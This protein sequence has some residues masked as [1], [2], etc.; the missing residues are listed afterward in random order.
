MKI[1]HAKLLIPVL[2]LA[3]SLLV[4]AVLLATAPEVTPT[5]REAPAVVVRAL[6]ATP[7]SVPL[8]V[9][10][11]GTVSP[12]TESELVPEISG[13]VIWTSPALA[14]GAFFDAGEPL[15]RIDPHDYEVQLRRAKA[16]IAR[17]ESELS[18]AR[19]NLER[20]AGLAAKNAASSAQQDDARRALRLAEA[21]KEEAEAGLAD[22]E[23]NLE[24][25][26][27]VAPY[28]GRVREERVD[29]GQF[30]SRGVG[31]ANLYSTDYAEVR[32][33]I[34]DDQLAFLDVPLWGRDSERPLPSVTL[35]A[36]FAGADHQWAGTIVRT[37][38]EIDPMTR[39]V[40][41]VARVEDP[42]GISN[43]EGSPSR[44]PLAPGLFVAAAI[45]GPVV[46]DV[47]IVPRS[48][49]RKDDHLLVIDEDDRLRRRKIELLR[50]DR[51]DVLVR[52]VEAG[53]R[54]C[55]S[56]LQIFM[57]GMKVQVFDD[58]LQSGSA[59]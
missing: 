58:S 18:Y 25:T 1:P 11:H 45:E 9:R 19:S 22:A 53:E 44:P 38:G 43:P 35:S 55:V 46:E 23:R 30:V 21:A 3:G 4:A 29:V 56:P 33:P 12:R 34:P 28:T 51:E 32:L 47:V 42:Y 6:T 37:E 7:Q 36:R 40:N 59:G 27:I 41:V 57:D 31:I 13:R 39:M 54:V 48:A 52:G 2:V 49:L 15:L 10:S 16:A 8:T 26:E 14:S 17:A 20:V 50:I 24:R 5:P